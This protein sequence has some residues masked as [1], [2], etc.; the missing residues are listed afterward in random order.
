[1]NFLEAVKAMKEGK[2]VRRKGWVDYAEMKLTKDFKFDIRNLKDGSVMNP[3]EL[4]DIEKTD[5]EIVEEKKTLS[6]KIHYQDL[7][8]QDGFEDMLMLVDVKEAIQEFIKE[9]EDNY[10]VVKP[11]CPANFVQLENVKCYAKEIFGERLV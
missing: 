10:Q 3:L 8:N 1:M 6:D 5:W 2:K 7:G 4:N 9:C 11:N